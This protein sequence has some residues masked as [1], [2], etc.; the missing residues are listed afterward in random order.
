MLAKDL[1]VTP[2]RL[3]LQHIGTAVTLRTMIIRP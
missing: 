2:S 3:G 1:C